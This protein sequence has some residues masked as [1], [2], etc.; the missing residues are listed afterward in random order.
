MKRQLLLL[1]NQQRG[2]LFVLMTTGTR[3]KDCVLCEHWNNFD[4]LTHVA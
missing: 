1:W 2:A 3:E 4:F